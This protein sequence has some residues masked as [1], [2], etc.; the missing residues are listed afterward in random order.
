MKKELTASEMGRKG[1]KARI[2]KL[3]K[4]ELKAHTTMMAKA[5]WSKKSFPQES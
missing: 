1:G 4:E 2:K 5:R 3:S